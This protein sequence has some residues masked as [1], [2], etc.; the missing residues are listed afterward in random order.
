VLLPPHGSFGQEQATFCCRGQSKFN[1]DNSS[2][3]QKL[4]SEGNENLSNAAALL[5][6]LLLGPVKGVTMGYCHIMARL[7]K[8]RQLFAAEATASTVQITQSLSQKLTSEGNENLSNAAAL[9]HA[10]HLGPM[11]GFTMCYCHII[12][13][14]AKDKDRQLFAAEARASTVQITQNPSQ[15]LT[16]E[17]NVDPSSAAALLHALHLG[18]MKGVTM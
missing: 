9:L 8:D 15:M 5:H 13:H 14:L 18:P 1:A 12:V 7:G 16:S 4:T 3:S 10:L 11:K 2:L 6:A 17:G